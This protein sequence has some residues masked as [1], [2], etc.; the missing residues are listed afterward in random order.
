M[1]RIGGREL[2]DT[3]LAHARSGVINYYSHPDWTKLDAALDQF[4]TEFFKPAIDAQ[5]QP[6]PQDVQ[7]SGAVANAQESHS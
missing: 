4:Y 2:A 5:P 6:E 7:R 3:Y 1:E